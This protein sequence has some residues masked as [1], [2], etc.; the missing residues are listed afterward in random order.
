M[1]RM[2][3]FI[4]IGTKTY[5]TKRIKK[6]LYAIYHCN[7]FFKDEFFGY[8]DKYGIEDAIFRGYW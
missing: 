2:K 7:G 4:T 6:D 8:E 3:K 5:K 1:T